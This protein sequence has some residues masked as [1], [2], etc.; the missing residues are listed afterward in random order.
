MNRLKY[1]AL[2]AL[3]AFAACDEGDDNGGVGPTPT[4]SGTITG[5]VTAEGAGVP[6]ITVTLTGPSSQSATTGANGSFTFNNVEGGAYA[7]SISN[8]PADFVFSTTSQAVT[9]TQDGQ[10]ASVSFSGQIVRT[11]SISGQVT[12]SGTAVEGVAVTIS[13][14][15]GDQTK[16]TGASGNYSF[17][18][19]RSGSYTVSITN[20]NPDVYTFNVTEQDVTLNAGESEIVNFAGTRE[21]GGGGGTGEAATVVIQGITNIAG[22]SVPTNNIA[23]TIVVRASIDEGDQ[24]VTMVEF[25]LG[26][27]VI[28]NCTQTFAGAAQVDGQQTGDNF[29]V[30]CTIN[31]AQVVDGDARFLNGQTAMSVRITTA[32]GATRTATTQITLNN[33]DVVG[34]VTSTEDQAIGTGGLQWQDGDL[35]VTGMPV[36]YSGGSPVN[37][38]TF[39][40]H[41]GTLVGNPIVATRTDT[42]GSDGWSV[43]FP[44]ANVPGPNDLAGFMSANLLVSATTQT[45][46]G[47]VG[48]SS[49]LT[50]G[51]AGTVRYDNVAPTLANFQTALFIDAGGN[52]TRWVN[53][54]WLFRATSSGS[55]PNV[56]DAGVGIASVEFYA[57]TSASNLELVE[58]GDDLAETFNNDEYILQIVITDLL[59]N[60]IV[61]YWDNTAGGAATAPAAV[62]FGV[63]KGDPTIQ[64]VTGSLANMDIIDDEIVVTAGTDATVQVAFSD[65]RSGFPVNPVFWRIQRHTPSVSPNTQAGCFVGAWSVNAGQCFPVNSENSISLDGDYQFGTDPV[66]PASAGYGDGYFWTDV[67]V[68]DDAGNQSSMIE[69]LLLRDQGNPVLGG[70]SFDPS[71]DAGTPEVFQAQTSDLVDLDE[72]SV[73][74]GYGGTFYQTDEQSL[75]TFGPAEFTRNATLTGDVDNFIATTTFVTENFATD[76]PTQAGQVKFT[77]SD[78]A[79]G[80]TTTQ[81]TNTANIAAAVNPGTPPD[82]NATG[83]PTTQINTVD[84]VMN[85]TTICADLDADGCTIVTAQTV[86]FSFSYG[87]AGSNTGPLGKIFRDVVFYASLN[88]VDFQRI[89]TGVVSITDNGVTRTY[90]YTATISSSALV[91]EFGLT[92][93]DLP[94]NLTIHARA[95]A[96]AGHALA[97]QLQDAGNA[98]SL[99]TIVQD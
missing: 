62:T 41:D 33:A 45:E 36:R 9:I 38:V 5:T 42:D 22:G 4:I 23:G 25:L 37:Q 70:A 86:T 90:T 28:S 12:A 56:A 65:T 32:A 83:D 68:I 84:G 67:Y 51:Q 29:I 88:G 87:G 99:L 75:G 59:G 26:D 58:S 40:V 7:V 55:T 48:P 15:E 72:G 81:Q 69:L 8:I 78:F 95:Q 3:V 66:D 54:D 16:Q 17:T 46:A 77:V 47:Q 61:R 30:D 20:P 97:I 21:G 35:T 6:G 89:G 34:L 44:E 74:L 93:S 52:V 98:I 24:E 53:E 79:A 2:A 94:A 31:T 49:G 85:R 10:T 50:S 92:V 63:D 73:L 82:Y 1:L 14:A 27:E 96:D 91:D 60:Q 11:A 13:G 64:L 71:L 57:G 19:L 18:G 76:V 39:N 43:T 80:I